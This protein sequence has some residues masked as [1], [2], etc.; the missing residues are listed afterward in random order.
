MTAE[1]IFL[2]AKQRLPSLSIATVYRNLGLMV[3]DG[4]IRRV[5]IGGADRYDRNISPHDHLTCIRCGRL[6]DVT[7]HDLKTALEQGTGQK[8]ISYELN[9][10]Y[11]CP[12]CAGKEADTELM[13]E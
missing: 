5:T 3:R 4:E 7:L 11:V 1:E 9:M 6:A 13:G 8:I 12:E 10:Y 2:L